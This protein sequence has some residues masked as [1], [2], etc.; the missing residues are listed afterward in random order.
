[1]MSHRMHR[2]TEQQLL[3]L[4]DLALL[5]WCCFPPHFLCSILHTSKVYSTTMNCL[6]KN[7][8]KIRA[9]PHFEK[10]NYTNYRYHEIF[11]VNYTRIFFQL[12]QAPY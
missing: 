9:N 7:L 4:L 2:Q 8:V 12:N 11:S 6:V 3:L 10:E 5:G 1:M